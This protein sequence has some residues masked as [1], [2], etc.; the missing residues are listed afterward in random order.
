MREAAIREALEGVE[1]G[2]YDERI[3]T[4]LAGSDVATVGT[5]VSWLLRV[6]HAEE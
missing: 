2:A 3:V 4:W 6:R 1:L 5:A